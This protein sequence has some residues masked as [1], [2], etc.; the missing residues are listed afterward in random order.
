MRRQSILHPGEGGEPVKGFGWTHPEHRWAFVTNEGEEEVAVT[1]LCISGWKF[2]RLPPC[3]SLSYLS[4]SWS[5]CG[6]L[7]IFFG[8]ATIKAIIFNFCLI[9]CNGAIRLWQI[10]NMIILFE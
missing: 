6:V 10:L 4:V 9:L 7:H 3:L 8:T 2:L 1:K 5:S